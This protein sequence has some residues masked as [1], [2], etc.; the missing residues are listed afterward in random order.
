M[1]NKLDKTDAEWK[2][3]L[4]EEEFRILRGKGTERAFTGKYWDHKE[5]G[6]YQCAACGEELFISSN[7][8]DS[9]T[10]WPSFVAPAS[11]DAVETRRDSSHGM[12][13]TEVVCARC[14]GHL[15]HVFNDGPQPTGLR[16]CINSAALQFKA[17]DEEGAKEKP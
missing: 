3:E 16:Y 10:G 15:G 14:G 6:R 11:G 5:D 9:C 17:E 13:R 8:F 2:K 7:K 4:T 1:S 12:T